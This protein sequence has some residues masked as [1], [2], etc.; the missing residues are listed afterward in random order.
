M[1]D[2]VLP[3]LGED[4]TEAVVAHWH[5]KE[6]QQVQA[7]DDT[8]EMVTDKAT[9]NVPAKVSGII[10]EICYQKGDSVPIGAVLA[11]VE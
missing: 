1:Q 6:G 3:P 9:F 5:V 2:I 11:K 10:K 7:D 8:V 4:I